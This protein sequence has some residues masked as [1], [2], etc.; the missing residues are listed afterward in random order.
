MFMYVHRDI[1]MYHT[2]QKESRQ[3]AVLKENTVYRSHVFLTFSGTQEYIL[4]LTTAKWYDPQRQHMKIQV[5]ELKVKLHA[6][7]HVLYVSEWSGMQWWYTH[8]ARIARANISLYATFCH[9]VS[10]FGYDLSNGCVS[11][12][13]NKQISKFQV[14]QMKIRGSYMLKAVYASTNTCHIYINELPCEIP[15]AYFFFKYY[16]F[17]L[18]IIGI[19]V[20]PK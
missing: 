4:F 3:T 9:T 11:L 18:V 1:N 19:G 7:L 20:C 14:T 15:P 6:H 16:Y 17:L 2:W 10:I 13:K 5:K 8:Y 12:L